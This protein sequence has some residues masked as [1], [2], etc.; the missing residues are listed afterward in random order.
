MG[1][2][3]CAQREAAYG[4]CSGE[5]MS[6][7]EISSGEKPLLGETVVFAMGASISIYRVPDIIRDLRDTGASVL[8]VMSQ[9]SQTLITKTT[10]QWAAENDVLDSLSGNMEHIKIFENEP[11][12]KV[13][14][15]CPATYDQIGKF[16]SGVADGIID[17]MF[18]YALGHGIRIV[19]VPA[20][21]L[22][23]YTNSIISQNIEKLR[24]AGVTIV[25]PIIEDGKAKIQG[26]EEIID[27]I[28]R[29]GAKKSGKNVLIISGRSD[30]PIDPVRS[31]TNRSSGT[32]GIWISRWAYR[33]GFNKI[34]VI[35]N[36]SEHF[37]NYINLLSCYLNRDFYNTTIDEL[38]NNQ[39]DFVI[40]SAALSDYEYDASMKKID[41][42]RSLSLVLKPAKKLK[43]ILKEQFRIPLVNF[44]LTHRDK[45]ITAENDEIVVVN[46]IEDNVIGSQSGRYRYIV[47][48]QDQGE[49]L[50]TK[51]S[52]AEKLI[53]IIQEEIER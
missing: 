39:Y 41:S 25:D 49:D 13:L 30:L 48:G 10:I 6:E 33:S 46:Y 45:D 22:D 16:A 3:N 19:I 9:N 32:T 12:R 23:M 20:M 34:T 21:H 15:I 44:K 24:H 8:P 27:T 4:Q 38:K 42:S 29:S 26:S 2:G 53:R 35:G 11:G 51:S 28:I 52:M 50:M 14:L 36:A 7:S 1:R 43:A 47:K 31:I 37:P 40:V 17:T 5:S 18:A